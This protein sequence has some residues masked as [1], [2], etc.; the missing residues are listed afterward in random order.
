[1]GA[2]SGQ[3]RDTVEE[4]GGLE[5]TLRKGGIWLMRQLQQRK[6]SSGTSL[7]VQWLRLCTSNPGVPG[8]I[9]SQGTRSCMPQLRPGTA[10][11]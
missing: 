10:D 2:D 6:D 4:K 11:K 7:V 8:L 1:M 5:L 3:R 9:P